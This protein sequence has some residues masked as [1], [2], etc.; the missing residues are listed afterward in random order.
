MTQPLLLPARGRF[1]QTA[2]FSGPTNTSIARHPDQNASALDNDPFDRANRSSQFEQTARREQFRTDVQA[3]HGTPETAQSHIPANLGGLHWGATCGEHANAGAGHQESAQAQA[4][5]QT[6]IERA[7]LPAARQAARRPEPAAKA[8][9]P[10]RA[11]RSERKPAS[12]L[13]DQVISHTRRKKPTSEVTQVP[14]SR[15]LKR[16]DHE[17]LR[18]ILSLRSAHS[19]KHKNT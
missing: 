3:S 16:S 1:S 5:Q 6:Q 19:A 10:K 8:H 17:R 13:H 11:P 4:C 12:V 7:A 18:L 15:N 14:P 2:I 9:S